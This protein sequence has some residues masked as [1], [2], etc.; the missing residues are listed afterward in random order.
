M[1]RVISYKELEKEFYF[2]K[3][4]G[5]DGFAIAVDWK[6]YPQDMYEQP[7]Q[8]DYYYLM[9]VNEGKIL[10]TIEGE[11]FRLERNSLFISPPSST[12]IL[13]EISQGTQISCIGFTVDFII[14]NNSS[15]TFLSFFSTRFFPKWDLETNDVKKIRQTMKGIENR[16]SQADNEPF[17]KE[18]LFHSFI[19]LLYEIVGLSF[20]YKHLSTG[21]VSRKEA[22]ITKFTQKLRA[23]YQTIKS[24]KMYAEALFVT[25]KYLTETS[26]EITGKSAGQIINDFLLTEIKQLLN[27][28]HLSLSEIAYI[29]NF[30][31]LNSFSK[32]FKRHAAM[33][34]TQYRKLMSSL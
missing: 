22:L 15:Q 11:E 33:S 7:F 10:I 24:V 25:P 21:L 19:V 3:S 30:N 5:I 29:L 9:L 32:F 34:L 12:R 20:K 16:L 27:Q 14:K 1:K 18:L 4:I 31:D 23:N 13:K 8:T 17:K 6:T 28:P 26:K 2:N